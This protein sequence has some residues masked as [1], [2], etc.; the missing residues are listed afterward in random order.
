MTRALA[1]TTLFLMTAWFISGHAAPQNGTVRNRVGCES[2]AGWT[3]PAKAIGLPSS[4]ATIAA[5]DLIPASPQTV[6][7]D[8]AVLAIPEYCRVT[9]RIAPVDPAAPPI[10][11]HVNLPTSWNRKLAQMGGS[12]QNGVIPVAL[13]TGMQWGP[14]RFRPTRLTRCREGSSF[15][16][17]TRGIRARVATAPPVPHRLPTG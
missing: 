3:V 11:F 9:G 16:G 12:G 8:R 6:N 7:G 17:A 2:L 13:T 1:G 15:M 5:A 10:N 14:N 4:G